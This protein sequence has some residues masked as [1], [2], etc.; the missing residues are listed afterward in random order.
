MRQFSVKNKDLITILAGIPFAILAH[1]ICVIIGISPGITLMIQ[2][3][4][5]II[6]VVCLCLC[7]KYIWR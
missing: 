1:M 7:L 6:Q 3:P 5:L 4:L 2:L